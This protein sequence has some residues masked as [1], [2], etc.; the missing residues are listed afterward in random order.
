MT[1]YD[2]AFALMLAR[3]CSVNARAAVH[4]WRNTAGYVAQSWQRFSWLAQAHHELRR[5][6]LGIDGPNAYAGDRNARIRRYLLA[7]RDLPKPR[8]P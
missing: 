8:L 1:G 4:Y 3:S 2:P 5:A 6:L 7:I